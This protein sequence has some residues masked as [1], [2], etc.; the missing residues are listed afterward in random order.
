MEGLESAFERFGRFPEG[1]LFHRMG[2]VVMLSDDGASVGGLVRNAESL[3]FASHWGLLRR[4]LG[5]YAIPGTR[6]ASRS[7][8]CDS[9]QSDRSGSFEPMQ[10][11]RF[12]QQTILP[13]AMHMIDIDT[14]LLRSFLVVA[15]E[16]S[17]S[18][19]AERLGC[20]Q[21]TMS[22]RI[23]SLEKQLGHRLFHRARLN[24][25]VTAAGQD[26]L[27]HARS[28][29]DRHDRL[30][31]RANTRRVSGR[32]KLGVGEDHGSELF[33]R[34][35]QQLHEGYTAIELDIV[36]QSR[37]VLAEETLCGA[38]D[39]AIVT[40][41]EGIPSGTLLSRR[42]LQWVASRDFVF[43]DTA[44]L[45]VAC[46]PEGCSLREAGLAGLDSRNI[47]WRLA[48]CSP[49]EEVIRDAVSAGAA[50]TVMTEGTI[51]GDLKAIVR[52]S[53]LPP[54][55]RARIQ[56]LEKPGDQTGAALAVK[57]EVVNAFQ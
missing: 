38:L 16:K 2:A 54:L 50:I 3:R 35:R 27:P 49:S 7:G 41:L 45:P 56:L 43:D 47:D 19:A 37:R 10:T 39:L 31:E 14:K 26:L 33:S 32:V 48:I 42:R 40:S 52:P 23:R 9:V 44:P 13:Y 36:C 8:R 1:M 15:T 55:G 53:L 6:S 34:L 12:D 11:L 22:V 21:G 4:A 20:S 17:F 30:I 18:T 29:V 57:R 24:V 28:I 51:P 5:S 46:F 25:K